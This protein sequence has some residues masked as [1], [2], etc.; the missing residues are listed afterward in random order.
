M[1]VEKENNL[2]ETESHA[3]KACRQALANAG[4]AFGTPASFHWS[5]LINPRGDKRAAIEAYKTLLTEEEN[6]KSA[7][8][9]LAY[10]YQVMGNQNEAQYYRKKLKQV[11]VSEY[12]ILENDAAEV[13]EYL[14]AKTGEAEKPARVPETFVSAHFDKYAEIFDVSL[15]EQLQYAGPQLILNQLE[16]FGNVNNKKLNV[17]DLGCGTGLV[18]IALSQYASNLVGVDLSPKMLEKA[19]ER[20]CYSELISSDI[21]AYLKSQQNSFDLAC[22]GEVFNYYGDLSSVF[23]SVKNALS[24]AGLF[25]FTVE[26]YDHEE[27]KLCNTGRFQHHSDYVKGIAKKS[28]FEVLNEESVV[29]RKERDKAVNGLIY[30]LRA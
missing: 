21:E 12:G 28:G 15:T 6:S 25:I 8:E 29:L 30:C 2:N 9:G 7:L 18:G 22:A 24:P 3:E 19:A 16:S 13:V 11:E 1:F 14:L 4:F 26:A 23:E 5:Q 27:F 10:L 17:V 20:D